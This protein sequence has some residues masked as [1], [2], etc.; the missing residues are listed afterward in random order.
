MTKQPAWRRGHHFLENGIVNIFLRDSSLRQER[1]FVSIG[2][3][4]MRASF[5]SEEEVSGDVRDYRVRRESMTQDRRHEL[6]ED[7]SPSIW[8]NTAEIYAAYVD[9]YSLANTVGRLS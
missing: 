7:G 3:E 6:E 8:P 4:P 9:K 1:I 2:D 5:S